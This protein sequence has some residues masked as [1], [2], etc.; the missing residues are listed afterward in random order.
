MRTATRNAI[1]R[2]G[3]LLAGVALFTTASGWVTHA[4]AIEQGG[5]AQVP[6]LADCKALA[7]RLAVPVFRVLPP[8]SSGPLTT[9]APAVSP[10]PATPLEATPVF[11]GGPTS[12]DTNVQVA[13]VD[14]PD[15]VETDG[16]LVYSAVRGDLRIV[17]IATRRQLSATKFPWADAAAGFGPG[18]ELGAQ[19]ML[20]DKAM[21]VITPSIPGGPGGVVLVGSDV[22]VP[23]PGPV[24]AVLVPPGGPRSSSPPV[25]GVAVY[26]VSN[27]RL[28]TLRSQFTLDGSLF[29]ARASQGRVLLVTSNQLNG[30]GRF[31]YPKDLTSAAA[32]DEANRA[33]AA[34]VADAGSLLP[35]ATVDGVR[36]H[37]DCG[38]VLA[39]NGTE[40]LP[41]MAAL[42]RLDLRDQRL[43]PTPIAVTF[44]AW[45][46]AG[47][48]GYTTADAFTLP[49]RIPERYVVSGPWGPR[50]PLFGNTLLR[51]DWRTTGTLSATGFVPGR[52]LDQFAM[53][54]YGG[55][56]RLATTTTWRDSGDGSQSDQSGVFVLKQKGDTLEEIGRVEGLGPNELIRSARFIGDYGYVVTFR[57]T[58]PLYTI[59]LKKPTAPRV[60]GVLEVSGYSD[61]LH[62]LGN[63]LLLGIGQEADPEN[64]RP[65]GS[66]AALFDVSNP[67]HPRELGSARVEEKVRLPEDWRAS[68]SESER[69]YHAF[70]WWATAAKSGKAVLPVN[71]WGFDVNNKLYEAS[72][73]AVMKVDG[74]VLRRQASIRHPIGQGET[75][76]SSPIRRS[77]VLGRNLV[78]VSRSGVKINDFVTIKPLAWIPTA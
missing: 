29:V 35:S 32:V 21:V 74:R 28:P 2:S 24:P 9:A 60:V 36:R 59:D 18:F 16:R 48:L 40:G 20:V 10:A 78:T 14:E 54:E 8:P 76:F 4:T 49:T 68:V 12:S 56:L 67:A 57:Q 30:A 72:E 47:N 25:V 73:V 19:I 62:P 45:P 71:S 50:K 55:T 41:S 33:N 34:V 11:T 37:L 46:E 3:A 13:G 61:Y 65:L 27:P 51:F 77:L 42:Y 39:P 66:K 26:D 6:R 63:H 64:G 5:A 17:D 44:A 38:A 58:D 7:E 23:V 43:A 75:G 31:V 15:L 69:D 52:L 53:D 22:G 70:L 1:R